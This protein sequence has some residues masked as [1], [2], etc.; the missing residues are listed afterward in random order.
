MLKDSMWHYRRIAQTEGFRGKKQSGLVGGYKSLLFLV[1][2][3]TQKQD[4]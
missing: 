4:G 3:V 1:S 2:R